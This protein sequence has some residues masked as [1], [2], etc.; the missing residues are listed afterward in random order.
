MIR[1]LLKNA[2]RIPGI[3]H[4]IMLGFVTGVNPEP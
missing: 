4:A 1:E 2:S 3:F